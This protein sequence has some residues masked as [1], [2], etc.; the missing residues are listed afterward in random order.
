VYCQ[1][2]PSELLLQV[3]DYIPVNFH[4]VQMVDRLQQRPFQGG[5]SRT[6]LHQEVI[7]GGMDSANDVR[8]NLGIDEK[9]L[10]ETLAGNMLH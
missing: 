5:Q 7:A 2:I 6:D 1:L 4:H 10:T 9:I 3:L 8:N